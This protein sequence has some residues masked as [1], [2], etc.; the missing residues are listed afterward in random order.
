MELDHTTDVVIVGSGSAA[1][2]SALAVKEAGLEPLI[3]ESTDLVGGSRR[4]RGGGLWIPNNPLT[5]EAGVPDS[6]EDARLYI[7]DVIGDADPASSPQRRDAFLR[8]GPQMVEW[9]RGLG[10]R[11]LY[12]GATATTTP[13]GQGAAPSGVASRAPHSTSRPSVPGRTS[14]A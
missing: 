13:S 8:Q 12:G 1:L 5:R 10:F 4:C 7:D 9:L 6:Y 14:C 3:L 2:T 11:F